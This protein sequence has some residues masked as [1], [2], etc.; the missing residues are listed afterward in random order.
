M[1]FGRTVAVPAALPN[2]NMSAFYFT[3]ST[4]TDTPIIDYC[5]Y[6]PL[7]GYYSAAHNANRESL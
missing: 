3:F 6:D 4:L 5:S 1:T 2:P 7:C